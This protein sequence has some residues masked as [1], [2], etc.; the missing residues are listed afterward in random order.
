MLAFGIASLIFAVIAIFIPG[1]GITVS[2]VSGVLA[3]LSA[4]VTAVQVIHMRII[5][6]PFQYQ[7]PRNMEL[8]C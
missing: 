8:F 4:T 6:L 1:F 7:Y 5:S 3:W 2:G